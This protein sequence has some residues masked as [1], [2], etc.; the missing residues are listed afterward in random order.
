MTA[1]LTLFPLRTWLRIGLALLVAVAVGWVVLEL[2][3]AAALAIQVE[4]LEA[5]LEEAIAC[6]RI[7]KA[8]NDAEAARLAAE[9][10]DRLTFGRLTDEASADP[11]AGAYSLGVR[12]I[13][14]LNAIR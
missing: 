12:S 10:S 6:D 11:T 9:Q 2:R 13:D 4:Q 5:Q 14:R 3:R 1:F 8:I 7:R